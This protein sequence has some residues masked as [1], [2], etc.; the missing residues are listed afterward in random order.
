MAITSLFGSDADLGDWMSSGTPVSSYNFVLVVEGIYD[1][2]IKSIHSFKKENE[3]EMIQEGGLNDYVHMRRKPISR[4][5]QFQIERY[6]G[7]DKF[8]MMSL[9]TD[10]I[11]P[12]ILCVSRWQ[13]PSEANSSRFYVFLGASV[14]EKEYGT[15]DAEKSGPRKPL[16]SPTK[17]SMQ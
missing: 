3:F 5:F 9:G 13:K 4:P 14:I 16:R 2:P 11:L 17:S 1:V 6:L 10:F 7:T 12:L 15:L 8:D